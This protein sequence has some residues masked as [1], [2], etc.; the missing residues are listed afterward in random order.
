MSS[1]WGFNNSRQFVTCT[2]DH[3]TRSSSSSKFL[4]PTLRVYDYC[5]ARIF[6]LEKPTMV[7]TVVQDLSTKP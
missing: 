2:R 3:H 7:L 4:L 5:T 6:Y 1:T